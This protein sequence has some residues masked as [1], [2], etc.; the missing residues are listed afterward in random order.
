MTRAPTAPAWSTGL[1]E[2][3]LQA[4]EHDGCPLLIVA[5]AGQAKPGRWWLAWPA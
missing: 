4:V 3:Q 5:G 2:L 1:D